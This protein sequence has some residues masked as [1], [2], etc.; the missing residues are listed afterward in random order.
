MSLRQRLDRLEQSQ[1]GPPIFL[2]LPVGGRPMPLSHAEWMTA[3]LGAGTDWEDVG[4]LHPHIELIVAGFDHAY[5]NARD[6]RIGDLGDLYDRDPEARQLA[7][8]AARVLDRLALRLGVE[9]VE[10]LVYSAD[11]LDR[12]MA[13]SALDLTEHDRAVVAIVGPPEGDIDESE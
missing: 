3:Y 12:E 6:P 11:P 7:H 13:A 4:R 10:G 2:T 5:R 8:R 9:A 1:A